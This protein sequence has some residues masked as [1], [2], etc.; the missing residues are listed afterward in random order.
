MCV[1]VCVCVCVTDVRNLTL[2]TLFINILF[3]SF[4]LIS[5]LKKVL[6][7]KISIQ[8]GRSGKETL[9]LFRGGAERLGSLGEGAEVT[10]V[11]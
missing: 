9:S 7:S 10:A 6:L 11:P 5:S 1:C 2:K 3:P 4:D 8:V